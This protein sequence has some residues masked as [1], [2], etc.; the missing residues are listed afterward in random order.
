MSLSTNLGGALTAPMIFRFIPALRTENPDDDVSD[1]TVYDAVVGDTMSLGIYDVPNPDSDVISISNLTVSNARVGFLM[2]FHYAI[3]ISEELDGNSTLTFDMRSGNL[4]V[5]CFTVTKYCTYDICGDP[6][7]GQRIS[8][9]WNYECPVPPG[10]YPSE[11]YAEIPYDA[12]S[13]IEDSTLY[14]QIQAADEDNELGC[15]QF[16]VTV[17]E[18]D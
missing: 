16:E 3:S 5:P 8:A 13:S 4:V 12:G 9:A 7:T 1:V 15:T 11:F 6:Y 17:E 14:V 10:K 18:F 2:S